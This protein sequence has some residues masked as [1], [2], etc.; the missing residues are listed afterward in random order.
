[1]RMMPLLKSFEPPLTFKQRCKKGWQWAR[2]NVFCKEM[3]LSVAIAEVIFWSPCIVTGFM[4]VF[5][6][7]YYWGVFG[8]ICAFWSMPLTPAMPLQF[9][10]AGAIKKLF[11][12]IQKRRKRK[13]EKLS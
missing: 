5:I 6:N 9:A 11:T 13:N 4:G 3:F 10:L 2:K 12:I 7:K 8:T 1:M